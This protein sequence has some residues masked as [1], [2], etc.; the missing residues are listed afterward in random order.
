[1]VRDDG[2]QQVIRSFT[3]NGKV[4]YSS[5]PVGVDPLDRVKGIL[6]FSGSTKAAVPLPWSGDEIYFFKDNQY[7]RIDT[8]QD[9]IDKYARDVWSMW[10]GLK[11]LGFAP[12]NAIFTAP[13]NE[14]EA[15][16]FCGSRCA[17][18]NTRS[19]NLA[20]NGGP[21]SFHEKWPSLKDA[22]FDT[23]DATMP[24]IFKGSEY[25]NVVCFFRKGTYA[26]ID[27]NRNVSLESGNIALRFNALAKASFKTIDAVV[28][29]PR[30]GKCQAYFF[31]GT[32][33]VL[34]DL[35]K[36]SIAWGPLDVGA[37]WNSLKDAGFY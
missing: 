14:N 32:Q 28:F 16:F 23:V 25:E 37:T 33:Y 26:L 18:L 30:K 21:F 17:R 8:I 4:L 13:D 12:I 9:T 19:G 6:G 31:S 35:S 20:D 3:K 1:M 22:G 2:G 11:K 36:D 34:V 7:A 5:I 15:Y 24:F 10:P 27:V 29:K